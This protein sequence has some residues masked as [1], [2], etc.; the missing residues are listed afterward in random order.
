MT[1]DEKSHAAHHGPDCE[2]CALADAAEVKRLRGRLEHAHIWREDA[3][4]TQRNAGLHHWRCRGCPAQSYAMDPAGS[5][6]QPGDRSIRRLA[7][8]H[9][10]QPNG[11]DIVT[12]DRGP[13]GTA[14]QVRTTE[15]LDALPMGSVVEPFEHVAVWQRVAERPG[16]AWCRVGRVALGIPP[17]PAHVRYRADRI[18]RDG[19][20]R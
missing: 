10:I 9:G 17:L 12:I 2:T 20:A 4:D 5:G 3:T 18:E 16:D 13:R 14:A 11:E 15:E 6:E 19:G 1:S 7:R 8:D